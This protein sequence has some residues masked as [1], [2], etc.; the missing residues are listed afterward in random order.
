VMYR[1]LFEKIHLRI[2]LNLN[3]KNKNGI[4]YTI[5]Y[6]LPS[7]LT[8]NKNLLCLYHYLPT[9]CVDRWILLFPAH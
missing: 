4:D 3:Y 2:N 7:S 6:P 9:L 1:M 8:A 5:P